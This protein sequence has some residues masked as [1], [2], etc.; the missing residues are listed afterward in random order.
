MVVRFGGWRRCVVPQVVCNDSGMLA[1][2]RRRGRRRKRRMRKRR[3]K[4]NEEGE[5]MKKEQ[6]KKIKN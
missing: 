4:G 6:E 2:W 1:Y 3:R 5:G